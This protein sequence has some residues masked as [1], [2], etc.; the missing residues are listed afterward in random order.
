MAFSEDFALFYRYNCFYYS[1]FI[2]DFYLDN[3]F[4]LYNFVFPLL[5]NDDIG[6]LIGES[7][8][9]C[10]ISKKMKASLVFAC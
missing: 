6:F 7:C 10:Y 9:S 4:V 1:K 5:Q 3:L 8:S 2:S